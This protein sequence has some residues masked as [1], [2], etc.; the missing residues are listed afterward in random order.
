MS[1]LLDEDSAWLP[2]KC[3]SSAGNFLPGPR[4]CVGLKALAYDLQILELRRNYKVD[5]RVPLSASKQENQS[6]GPKK[7][8]EPRETVLV[9]E[10]SECRKGQVR[11]LSHG[12]SD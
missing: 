3:L 12:E 9:P 10:N 11:I 2:L 4:K 7:V 6:W 5:N 1:Y 8:K